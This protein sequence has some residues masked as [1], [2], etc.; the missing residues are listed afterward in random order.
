MEDREEA[1][2]LLARLGEGP[3]GEQRLAVAHAHRGRRRGRLQAVAGLEMAALDDGLRE[4]AVFGQ[5]F[6][7]QGVRVFR[8]LG[9]VL[10]DHQQIL[11]LGYSS[12]IGWIADI[13]SKRLRSKRH[14]Q[15]NLFCGV[16]DPAI[17]L[18]QAVGTLITKASVGRTAAPATVERLLE[19]KVRAPS[20]Y[21]A[22]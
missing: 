12:L 21:G 9:F 17:G 10:V 5:H 16:P 18:T 13:Q 19:R 20:T 15:D 8:V 3:V 14:V 1:A 2:E 22:G 6:P 11:H 7:V 4:G